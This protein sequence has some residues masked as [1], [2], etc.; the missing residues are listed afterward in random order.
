M[1]ITSSEETLTLRLGS[2]LKLPISGSFQ[3]INGLDLLLQDI[4]QLLLTSPGE[5][6]SRPEYG[7]GLQA[8]VW[9]NL[10]TAAL[11]GPGIIRSALDRFEPRIR[12]TKVDA[13]VNEN[14]GLVSFIIRFAVKSTD[15]SVNLIFPLRVGT[16][17]SFA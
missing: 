6:V 5:R 1:A 9:E 12:T 11:D 13:S 4:Q 3:S 17:L 8:L 2:D 7:S 16:D 14:T 10:Q 15:T